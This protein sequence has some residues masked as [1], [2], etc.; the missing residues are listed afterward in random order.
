MKK[1]FWENPYQTSLTTKVASVEGTTV[2]F[3]DT[4][5]YSFAGGQESD[6]AYVNEIPIL[7]SKIVG[8]LIYYTLPG[9]HGLSKAM[10]LP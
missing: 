1:I 7:D 8:N 5:A 3:D 9:N 10:K 2:L 6:K 4:I